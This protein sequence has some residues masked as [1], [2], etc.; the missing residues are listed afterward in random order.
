MA[1]VFWIFSY[2]R[3]EFLKNCVASIEQCAPGCTIHIFD[4][5][6][7]DAQ[8]RALLAELGEKYSVHVPPP[9]ENGGNKHGGLYANMQAAYELC[10]PRD[11]VCFLQDDTQLVRPVTP[12]EIGRL[13]AYCLKRG[14]GFV[15]AAFMRGSDR[16]KDRERTRFDELGKVYFVD[17]LSSSAGAYYSDICL[18]QVQQL[19]S[20]DWRFVPRES[21]NEQAARDKLK[22]MAYWR[23][24]FVAWLPYVP[25]F[26]GKQQTWA[27]RWAQKKRRCG[28]YP[29]RLMGADETRQFLSRDPARLPYAE[30]FLRAPESLPEPWIYYPLQ[31]KSWLKHLNSLEIKVRRWLRS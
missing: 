18:F 5:N 19:R 6:S 29:L 3:A 27:L 24:P 21:H 4:D 23:D 22:Q 31:G 8:T 28:F 30:D 26:R 17:R 1:L 25:A 14:P 15:Q 20:A 7:S 11:L 16:Q 2:N 9:Q 13:E 10:D 12:E